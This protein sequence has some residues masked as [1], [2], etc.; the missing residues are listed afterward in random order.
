MHVFAITLLY[1]LINSNDR[2]STSLYS[3]FFIQVSGITYTIGTFFKAVLH[4]IIQSGKYK[5]DLRN[6]I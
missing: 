4:N 3:F 5:N 2:C 1:F 6:T